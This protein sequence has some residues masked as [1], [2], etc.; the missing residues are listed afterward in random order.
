MKRARGYSDALPAGPLPG[1]DPFIAVTDLILFGEKRL[2]EIF[3]IMII[4]GIC[5]HISTGHRQLFLLRG[6]LTHLFNPALNGTFGV[7]HCLRVVPDTIGEPLNG[8]NV[9]RKR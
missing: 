8:R 2:K 9:I 6:I 4:E 1:V 3:Q 7:I 5:P